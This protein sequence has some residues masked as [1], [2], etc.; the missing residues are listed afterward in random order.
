MN[1]NRNILST[2]RVSPPASPVMNRWNL[3]RNRRAFLLAEEVVFYKLRFCNFPI[4]I[5]KPPSL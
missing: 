2:S 1:G 4:K 5:L 3:P